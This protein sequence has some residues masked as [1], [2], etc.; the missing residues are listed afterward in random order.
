MPFQ[1]AQTIAGLYG[2]G[3]EGDIEHGENGRCLGETT[4]TVKDTLLRYRATGTEPSSQQQSFTPRGQLRVCIIPAL[5]L[6]GLINCPLIPG[7]H[8]AQGGL[9]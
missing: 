9:E 5:T 3:Q 4:L 7:A 6:C 1:S 2:V 8:Q